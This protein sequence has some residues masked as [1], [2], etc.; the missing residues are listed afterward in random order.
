[1]IMRQVMRSVVIFT[2]LVIQAFGISSSDAL[3]RLIDGN[4]RYAQD[5]S[6]YA[7]H[8]AD[9]RKS[10]LKQQSPFAT[11]VSCSD[12]RVTPEIIFDQGVGELFVVRIAGNVAGPIEQDSIDYS[13]K[14]LNSPLILVLGHE[15]CG[16]VKAVIEK[17]TKDIEELAALIKPA[18]KEKTNLEDAVKA[19]VQYVVES[20]QK[21]PYLK[22]KMAEKKLRCVGAYYD[23]D[24]GKVEILN[25][26]N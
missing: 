9:R 8:S 19:N 11:I 2:L 10:L 6:Q 4:I 26:A 3:Q 23:L 12:S 5:Q 18:V 1:M 7:D 21:N 16:A 14:V 15:G 20:F 13:I 22:Q 25:V 17:N 24:T